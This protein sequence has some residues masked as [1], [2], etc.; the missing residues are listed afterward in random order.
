M[1]NKKIGEFIKSLR[2]EKRLTQTEL[3]E[4]LSVS[5]KTIS[6]WECGLGA[7]DVSIMMDLCRELGITVNELLSGEKI[8]KEDYMEKAE[9]NFISVLEKE[10]R[11][12]KNSKALVIL[13]IASLINVLFV[14]GF[15]AYVMEYALLEGTFYKEWMG[16]AVIIFELIILIATIFPICILDNGI[17]YFKCKNCGKTFRPTDKA[18]ILAVHSH[19]LRKLK[20]PH[21]GAKTWCKRVL[22]EEKKEEKK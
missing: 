9:E 14:L 15:V 4:K 16:I 17:A 19:T 18:Y 2:K 3:A 22:A 13:A 5:D 20:C 7:P 1:D 12:K 11:N 6:K 21:C 8:Q 10:K